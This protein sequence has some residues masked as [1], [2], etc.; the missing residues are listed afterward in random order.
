MFTTVTLLFIFCLPPV[1]R[2]SMT[3]NYGVTQVEQH[4]QLMG[5]FEGK[6]GELRNHCFE[7]QHNFFRAVEEH[8]EAF[9]NSMGQLAQARTVQYF[10]TAPSCASCVS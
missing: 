3:R 6:Y 1:W 7:M 2:Y 10:C 8:E 5:E 4:E 9:F